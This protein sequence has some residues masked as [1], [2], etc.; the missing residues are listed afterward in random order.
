VPLI[1]VTRRRELM[2]SLV[3]TPLTTAVASAVA[4]VIVSLNLFL[5]ADLAF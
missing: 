3:N 1:L 5:L 2:G 4:A